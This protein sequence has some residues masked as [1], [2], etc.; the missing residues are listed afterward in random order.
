MLG[1]LLEI[2]LDLRGIFE[3]KLV[4]AADAVVVDDDDA[5][6]KDVVGAGA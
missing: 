3:E 4:V 2:S 1:H 5:K 6:P